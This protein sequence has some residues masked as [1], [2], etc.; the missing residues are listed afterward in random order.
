M[1]SAS[2]C[3]KS[4]FGE[5]WCNTATWA[6]E[7]LSRC[8]PRRDS[9]VLNALH[10]PAC[11][12]YPARR[13]MSK[14]G[15]SQVQVSIVTPEFKLDG[16]FVSVYINWQNARTQYLVKNQRW[17][18]DEDIVIRAVHRSENIVPA[19]FE[20]DGRIVNLVETKHR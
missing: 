1:P 10:T 19:L 5:Q 17:L 2:S 12:H 4:D 14:S 7:S 18:D 15:P 16:F 6:C 9:P 11:P 8:P 3:W 20:K 13:V